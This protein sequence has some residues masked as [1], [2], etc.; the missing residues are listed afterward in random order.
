MPRSVRKKPSIE[1]L[2]QRIENVEK[3]SDSHNIYIV[4]IAKVVYY[5]SFV[6][7][8]LGEIVGKK[9]NTARNSDEA[10]VLHD[11]VEANLGRMKRGEDL[12]GPAENDFDHSFSLSETRRV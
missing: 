3:R 12:V 9:G 11:L 2:I 1:E 7:S 10:Y 4:F 5:L 6:V 8:T